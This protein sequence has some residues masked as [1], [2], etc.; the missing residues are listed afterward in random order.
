MFLVN[1]G[2]L[3]MKVLELLMI[4][5]DMVKIMLT[6]FKHNEVRVKDRTR[7]RQPPVNFR[8]NHPFTNLKNQLMK[9]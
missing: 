4:K 1:S 5:A 8:V 7:A 6:A 3:M 2:K 9:V